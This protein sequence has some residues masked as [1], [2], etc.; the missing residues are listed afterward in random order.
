MAVARRHGAEGWG[1][2]RKK[3][4]ENGNGEDEDSTGSKKKFWGKQGI[5]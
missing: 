1:P 4:T 3:T 2:G 5:F